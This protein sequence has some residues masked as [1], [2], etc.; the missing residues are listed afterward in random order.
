M[1]H[2][3]YLVA[4]WTIGLGSLAVYA[5]SLIAR[6]RRVSRLVPP[7]RRRW[8]DSPNETRGQR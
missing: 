5:A 3:G 7:E 1:T 4:G 6:A 2:V 8:I